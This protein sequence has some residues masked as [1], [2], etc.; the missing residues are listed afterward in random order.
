MDIAMVV[1]L[2]KGA[3]LRQGL[4]GGGGWIRIPAT[5]G[6]MKWNPREKKLNSHCCCE[7]HGGGNK[8]KMGHQL[9]GRGARCIGRMALWLELGNPD[10][11]PTRESHVTAK[12]DGGT[13]TFQK[14]R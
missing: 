3:P 1:G 11:N 5:N 4:G 10:L 6:H 9:F 14:L 12:A 13:S 2:R 7:G 8:C